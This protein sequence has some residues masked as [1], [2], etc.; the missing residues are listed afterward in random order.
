MLSLQLPFA[1]IP[2]IYA[3]ADK[4]R[5]GEFSIKPWL[6][7]IAWIVA[8]II[9][10]LNVKLVIDQIGTWVTDAG[11]NAWLIQITVIPVVL[12]VGGLLLYVAFEPWLRGRV[13]GKIGWPRLAVAG[14]HREPI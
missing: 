12:A 13:T 10:V 3:V 5:M 4:Q 11:S 2:L 8:T 14:V 6:Q 1:I 9:L 7:M